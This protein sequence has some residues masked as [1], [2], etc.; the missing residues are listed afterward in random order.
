MASISAVSICNVALSQLGEKLI[1]SLDD[2]STNAIL[3]NMFYD[4]ARR[5]ALQWHA[6]NFAVRRIELPRDVS[7]PVYGFQYSYS[8]PADNLRLLQ[9]D[10]GNDFKVEGNKILTNA[11]T[12]FIKYVSDINDVSAW[13]QAFINV[14]QAAMRKDLSFPITKDTGQASLAESLYDK[15]LKQAKLIDTSED[16]A[17]RL[18][19]G[20]PSLI[21]VRG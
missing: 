1:H 10:G 20:M 18:G 12:C 5:T 8:L 2:E 15:A 3:C 16:G 9:V 11:R 19:S 13:S 7:I 6:W 4:S 14:M 21:A 17:T